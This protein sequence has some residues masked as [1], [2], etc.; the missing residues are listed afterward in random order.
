MTKAPAIDALS[1]TLP[2]LERISHD[3]LAMRVHRGM[4]DMLMTGQVQPGQKLTLRGLAGA[5]GTSLMP[6]REAV[7]RLAVEGAL[8]AL[9]NRTIRVPVMTKSRFRE[10]RT[11]RLALEGLAVETAAATFSAAA[12]PG[13]AKLNAVFGRSL[14][15]RRPDYAEAFRANKEIHFTV[16]E[17]AGMPQLVTMIESLWLQIG[18]VLYMSMLTRAKERAQSPARDWHEALIQALRDHDAAAAR[19]ALEGDL[20]SAGDHILAEG[21]LPD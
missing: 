1:D 10:L 11:I 5:L 19:A 7:H 13:M 14:E 3:T 18:P 16:Y 8:E 20:M 9:P 21:D 2:P 15:R 4:R 12:L 17:A 6:V